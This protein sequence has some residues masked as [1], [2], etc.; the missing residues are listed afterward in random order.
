LKLAP[1]YVSAN[2][3][4]FVDS[5]S[6]SLA[7]AGVPLANGADDVAYMLQAQIGKGQGSLERCG[8]LRN[9]TYTVDYAVDPSGVLLSSGRRSKRGAKAAR[10]KAKGYVGD[11]VPNVFDE[12]AAVLLDLMGGP[13]PE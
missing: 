13:V 10:F 7:R 9:I 8:Y 3:P 4:E 12:M 6:E 11:C 1:V 5:V 2:R